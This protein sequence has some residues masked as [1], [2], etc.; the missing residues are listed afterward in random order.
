[1][2]LPLAR[3]YWSGN[4]VRKMRLKHVGKIGSLVMR[5]EKAS[6]RYEVVPVD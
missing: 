2:T 1:M 3:A 4:H 6:G 5:W